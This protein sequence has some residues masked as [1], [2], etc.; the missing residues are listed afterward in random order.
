MFLKATRLVSIKLIMSSTLTKNYGQGVLISSVD[1]RLVFP[2]CR[3]LYTCPPES[4]I[5]IMLSIKKRVLV[6]RELKSSWLYFYESL[7]TGSRKCSNRLD[8]RQNNNE[9]AISLHLRTLTELSG[10]KK[11]N[12]QSSMKNEWFSWTVW[13]H[14]DRSYEL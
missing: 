1:K 4:P 12:P 6:Q 13:N 9:H 2:T 7:S 11:L 3:S 14:L 8:R 10:E 5:K